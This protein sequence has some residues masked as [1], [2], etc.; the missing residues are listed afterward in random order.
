MP[1]CL[2]AVSY[3]SDNLIILGDPFLRKYI[4][5][6]DYENYTVTFGENR[7]AAVQTYPSNTGNV[8][9]F[10]FGTMVLAAEVVLLFV[11]I[12]NTQRKRMVE[13]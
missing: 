4:S 1:A 7:D 10:L 6:F 9:W 13:W 8:L 3:M 5:A 11:C 12:R 2:V